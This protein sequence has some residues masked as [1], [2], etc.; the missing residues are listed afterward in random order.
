[1]QRHEGR[2]H[3]T[4][5]NFTT[6]NAAAQSRRRACWRAA[7]RDDCRQ[8][9]QVFVCPF[10]I[11]FFHQTNSSAAQPTFRSARWHGWPT[12]I[13][14][15]RIKQPLMDV[16]IEDFDSCPGEPTYALL[17]RSDQT[18]RVRRLKCESSEFYEEANVTAAKRGGVVH[19]GINYSER[20]FRI[21]FGMLGNAAPVTA[22]V[23]LLN[24]FQR[25]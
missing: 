14:H 1:M 8:P 6:G 5:L 22:L 16:K 7:S 21:L 13:S 9:V 12:E 19:A 24:H 4:C 11:T 3:S 20:I 18:I 25:E 23:R 15:N 17:D 2:V 10:A